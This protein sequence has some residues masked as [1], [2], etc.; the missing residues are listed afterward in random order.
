MKTR[1]LG[2]ATALITMPFMG[3]PAWAD[4]CVTA[5]VSTYTA[6]GFS[7]SVGDMTF[8]GFLFFRST[9][10]GNVSVDLNVISPFINGNEL[11]LQL[12]LFQ[13][14]EGSGSLADV[15]WEY[16]VS[17]KTPIIDASVQLLGNTGG[18][19]AIELEKDAFP[20]SGSGIVI[21]L[22][23]PGTATGTFPQPVDELLVDE[24]SFV[25]VDH[26]SNGGFATTSL[27]VNGFSEVPGPIAGA[28]LPGLI[29]ASGGLLG[30]W[31]RRKKIA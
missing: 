10:L 18:A 4:A 21:E 30:W 25:S 15:V 5:P 11:G 24:G 20:P 16:D 8:S 3:L 29:L 14:A 31:R 6:P 1:R 22:D 2:I 28:G 9:L 7:C 23:G 12:S 13:S 27:I 26:L 17:S 19:G